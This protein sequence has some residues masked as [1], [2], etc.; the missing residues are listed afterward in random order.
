[1]KEYLT[2]TKSTGGSS[3]YYKINLPQWLLDK[4]NTNGYI[5]LEDLAELLFKNDFNYTNIFKAQKRMFELEQGAGKCGNTLEY[6]ATKCKY[7]VDKQVEV[8]N[9][10]GD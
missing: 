9:R 10:K 4:Q 3:S 2:P 5:M 6:D 7:Y 8:F 1:M